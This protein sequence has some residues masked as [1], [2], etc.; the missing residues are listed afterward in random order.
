MRAWRCRWVETRFLAGQNKVEG[1]IQSVALVFAP[2]DLSKLS[3]VNTYNHYRYHFILLSPLSFTIIITITTAI[4]MATTIIT[5]TTTIITILRLA[6][7]S[8]TL[9]FYQNSITLPSQHS[10][11]NI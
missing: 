2:C 3:N 1:R 6:G 11:C 7:T 8:V 9:D 4:T 5:T 10:K